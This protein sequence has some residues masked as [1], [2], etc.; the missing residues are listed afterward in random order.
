MAIDF[1]AINE[2]YEKYGSINE[3]VVLEKEKSTYWDMNMAALRKQLLLRDKQIG[4]LTWYI[5]D[6]KNSFEKYHD[7]A[8]FEIKAL[9]KQLKKFSTK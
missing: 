5:D 6:M 4:K 9:S 2:R 3:S 7:N 1:K 8:E